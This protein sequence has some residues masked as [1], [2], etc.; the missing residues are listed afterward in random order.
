MP[1]PQRLPVVGSD[2]GTWG[3]ILNNW[4]TI[5]HNDPNN[6]TTG[7]TYGYHKNVT[8]VAG[9]NSAAPLNF[10]SGTNLTSAT[11]GAMEY[12]GTNFYLTPVSTRETILFADFSNVTGTL[13]LANGGT[14]ATSANAAFNNLAPAQGSAAGQ[15]LT[16]NGTNTSWGY[17]QTTKDYTADLLL[18]GL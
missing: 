14:N 13:G 11:A 18:G 2:D 6:G 1:T 8:I 5:N 15:Y 17:V 12:D 16:T 10:T 7:S 3:T 9:T 4:L